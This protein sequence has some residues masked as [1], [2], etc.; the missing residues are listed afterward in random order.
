MK[1]ALMYASVASMI[2]LFNMNNIKLLRDLG[3]EVD[4]ACNFNE[5]NI[6]SDE[7]VKEFRKELTEMGIQFFNIPIP[8]NLKQIDKIKESYLLTFQL[9]QN[10]KYDLVHC[11]SPIGSVICRWA[12]RKFDVKMFYTAHG[13]HFYN[14]ASKLNWS[15][16]YPI[17]RWMSYFT[18]KLITINQEDYKR[19]KGFP[20]RENVE[21]VNGIGVDLTKFGKKEN[22]SREELLKEQHI[23]DSDFLM[24]SVGQLSERKNHKMVIEAI[25]QLKNDKI[26]YIIIGEGE[27]ESK[28]IQMIKEKKLEKQIFLLGYKTD[29][30]R[31][32]SV[33]DTFIFPSIQEGLPASLMEAMSCGLS[34]IVSNIRGNNDLI[35]DNK[36]GYLFELNDLTELKNSI[37]KM[38]SNEEIQKKFGNYN[39]E[40]IKNFSSEVVNKQM[41]Q[42]YSN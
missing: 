30:N 38:N 12:F 18:D 35:I 6:T 29:V 32:L 33:S 11:H 22:I 21:L 8:R 24:I 31:Y 2:D 28:L 17:E 7:R 1:R 9:A 26:K 14:G 13:F 34:C 15:L 39:K 10:R 40:I 23:S 27:L 5:G 20:V 37:R 36:G 3:Y 25:S 19:A 4:V 42:I 16:F 41:L